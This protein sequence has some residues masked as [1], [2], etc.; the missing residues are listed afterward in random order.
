MKREKSKEFERLKVIEKKKYK[1][2]VQEKYEKGNVKEAWDGLNK[3]MG[4][5]SKQS[6]QRLPDTPDPVNDLNRFYARFDVRD[7]SVECNEICQSIEPEFLEITESEVLKVFRKQKPNKAPGPDGVKGKV[8][9]TCASQLSKIFTLIFQTLLNLHIMP[10]TWKSSTIIPIP[11][12][13]KASLPNDFRPVALTPILAKCFESVLCQ[14]LKG[15]VSSKLDPLQFAYKAKRGVDDACLTLINLISKHLQNAEASVRILM[16]DFSSAFNSIEP[17]VL[18]KRLIDLG[19]NSNLILFINDFLKERPQRVMANGKLSD[20]LVLS[21]GA[22]QGCVLSPTLFSI[23]TDEIRLK[24]AITT[25]FKFADDM[26]LV[27]LLLDENSLSTYFSDVK[28][29]HN[30]CSESYLELNVKK[31]KELVFETKKNN[32]PFIPITISNENVDVVDSFKYLGTIIDTKLSFNENTDNIY[33]KCQQRLYLLRKLKSFY[34]CPEVLETVYRSMIESILTF[35]IVCWFG[36][37]NI[38]QK[39]KLNRIVNLASKIIGTKQTS[40]SELYHKALTRKSRSIVK[41]EDHPLSSEFV[42][43]PSKR[44]FRVPMS[45]KSF[46]KSYIPSAISV[47]NASGW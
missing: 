34:V 39:N 24:N 40:M 12:N 18:L 5:S 22:P 25:L 35:N 19:V 17:V 10:R 15:Q 1:D 4:R 27:G 6:H 30:W 13:A 47:L 21:T 33:K 43:L 38:V 2:K 26:A 23:Y 11:K 7:F 16:I 37:L 32:V 14:H 3:M 36:F 42:L 46:R 29:L 20:E 45:K 44:R 41:L 31:T 8:I 28:K 9:K